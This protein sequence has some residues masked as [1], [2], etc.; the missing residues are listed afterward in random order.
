M[1]LAIAGTGTIAD[2]VLPRLSEWG[3]RASA[4]CGTPRSQEKV[5]ELCERYNILGAYTDYAAMLRETETDAVYIAVPNFLHYEFVKQALE[6]GR[7]V[8]V[9]KPMTSN[10]REAVKLAGLAREKKLFLFEA[11]TT[12][13]LPNYQ[14]LREWVPRIGAVKLVSC[15]FSQYSRR[16]DAFR[17]GTVLP[18]FD[19]EKSGGALMD[20][21]LYNLHW[22][23]G[24]FGEPQDMIY[25]A[26]MERGIDTSGILTLS[27]SD[28]Q[29][30]SIAAK[31][32]SAPFRY[33]I[34][35]TDGYIKQDTPANICG[36]VTLRLNN[37][38]EERFDHNPG[39]RME[40]EF[41]AFA[42]C[43]A[44]GDYQRCETALNQSLLVSKVQTKVRIDAG[45]LFPADKNVKISK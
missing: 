20:L 10:Y 4:L 33:T 19:P 32:C 12:L 30:V 13:Y 38:A 29:A 24:L 25:H 14:K 6:A 40:S 11:I 5:K 41:R 9:E 43:I 42:D 39:N 1:K 36:P 26:N 28:F 35:G 45:I 3:W 34:Q 37:G 21:N 16:Y 23:L 8:I 15:N 17:A 18:V 27:Y 22:I 7:N 31:D 2:E 44:H